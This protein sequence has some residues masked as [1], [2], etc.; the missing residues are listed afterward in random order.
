MLLTNGGIRGMNES[1]SEILH[2]EIAEIERLIEEFKERF[3]AGTANADEFMTISQLE[4]MWSEL[5]SKT[6]NIYSDMIRKMMS[7]VDESDLIRKKK[8]LQAQ[9]NSAQNPCEKRYYD[10]NHFR[11]IVLLQ[12]LVDTEKCRKQSTPIQ[13]KRSKERSP[14][15]FLSG[16]I[17]VAV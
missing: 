16:F 13:V 5:Q 2:F 9:G 17:W 3:A 8:T 12:I 7:E 10:C 14:H 11:E 15:G 4:M 1:N 6:N